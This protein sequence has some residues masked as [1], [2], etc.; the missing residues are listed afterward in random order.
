MADDRSTSLPAVQRDLRFAAA[1]LVPLARSIVGDRSLAEDVVQGAVAEGLGRGEVAARPGWL[2]RLVRY[3]ALDALRDRRR[4]P[5]EEA[6]VELRDDRALDPAH[7]AETMEARRALLEAVE[8]LREPYRTTIFLRYFEDLTPGEIAR[9][10]GEPVKTVK[11]RLLRALAL[12]RSRFERR[13][14]LGALAVLARS[15]RPQGVGVATKVF[16]AAS[17]MTIVSKFAVVLVAALGLLLWSLRFDDAAA[18]GAV[19]SRAAQAASAEIEVPGDLDVQPDARVALERREMDDQPDEPVLDGAG[20]ATGA[21]PEPDPMKTA[22]EVTVRWPD[23]SPAAG[24]A[25]VASRVRVKG[26]GPFAGSSQSRFVT[27]GLGVITIASPSAVLATERVRVRAERGR[28]GAELVVDAPVGKTTRAQVTLASGVTIEGEVV[29]ADG[30]ARGG[31]GIW[32][33]MDWNGK[34]KGRVI[35][36]SDA[37]GR[38]ELEHIPRDASL[39]AFVDGL[40]TGRLTN[41]DEVD[42]VWDRASL[43][44]VLDSVGAEVAG[45]VVDGDG[46]PLG[47][48]PVYAS[49]EFGSAEWEIIDLE[50]GTEAVIEEWSALHAT[51]DAEGRFHFDSVPQVR[52]TFRVEVEGR[53][54]WTKTLQMEPGQRNEVELVIGRPARLWGTVMDGTGAPLAGVLVAPFR[55][56]VDVNGA[57]V[58]HSSPKGRVPRSAPGGV[59]TAEDGTF[60]LE[61]LAAGETWVIACTLGGG[62]VL[63]HDIGQL[64]LPSGADLEWSPR[65]HD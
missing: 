31:A 20:G 42:F 25:I 5:R 44:L 28:A 9:R 8:A 56:P 41:L 1:G 30:N 26:S 47:G 3:R 55:F 22:L 60:E 33:T 16:T 38:F 27:D 14:G 40:F 52:T 21:E 7:I 43:R 54:S 39:G 15:G 58:L 11:T 34:D 49:P 12:L 53:A 64:D 48:V 65:L 62:E 57:R 17:V 46:V 50:D 63:S 32:L 18:E 37:N 29:D 13:S 36:R 4:G 19:P 10:Q 35:A 59:L 23:G 24:V 51:T 45:R 2:P 61:G 6:G